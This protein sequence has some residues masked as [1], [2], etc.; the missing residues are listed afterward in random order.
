M[1]EPSTPVAKP[2]PEDIGQTNERAQR[3]K[4]RETMAKI[5]EQY[6][7]LSRS[8]ES[9]FGDLNKSMDSVNEKFGKLVEQQ[10]KMTEIFTKNS[11][12]IDQLRKSLDEKETK[13]ASLEEQ[14]KD[15]NT[16]LNSCEEKYGGN[17]TTILVTLRNAMSTK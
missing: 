15:M 17:R 14:M 8:I 2:I 4:R 9:K 3:I 7:S 16:R 5:E 1:T 10:G 6:Q 11:T 13:I 12:D